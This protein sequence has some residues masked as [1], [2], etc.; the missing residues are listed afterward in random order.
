M[1]IT[2][3]TLIT[4]RRTPKRITKEFWIGLEVK[5]KSLHPADRL[6]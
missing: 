1:V 2:M 4:E 5:M 3:L 6:K